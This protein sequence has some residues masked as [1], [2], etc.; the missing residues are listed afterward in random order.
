MAPVAGA[1]CNDT[2]RYSCGLVIG[3]LERCTAGAFAAGGGFAG[4][5]SVGFGAGFD[6]VCVEGDSVDDRGGNAGV[7]EH[8][9][10]FAEGEVGPDPME[11]LPLFR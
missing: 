6:D 5:E 10:P 1:G 9:S 8:G 7:G 3:G 11:A 2:H 4:A